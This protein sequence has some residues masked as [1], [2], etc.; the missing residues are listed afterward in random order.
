MR[1][2]YDVYFMWKGEKYFA[3]SHMNRLE[4]QKLALKVKNMYPLRRVLL[5]QGSTLLAV[6]D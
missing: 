4:A 2:A 3:Y 5:K 6:L 1:K